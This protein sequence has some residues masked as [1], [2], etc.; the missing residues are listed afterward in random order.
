MGHPQKQKAWKPL[1]VYPAIQDAFRST[2]TQKI[3]LRRCIAS[4]F[5]SRT[6]NI[7]CGWSSIQR[8][9]SENGRQMAGG[10]GDGE[11]RSHEWMLLFPVFWSL[12]DQLR[13]TQ[14][15]SIQLNFRPNLTPKIL[16]SYLLPKQLEHVQLYKGLH[17]RCRCCIPMAR[18][19]RRLC[20]L[21]WYF[22]LSLLEWHY[23]WN[24][25]RLH[26]SACRCLLLFESTFS[27]Q[28][29]EE[30]WRL[31]IGNCLKLWNGGC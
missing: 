12:F 15:L 30:W 5:R 9:F 17:L 8:G 4:D 11:C 29:G 10:K 3:E 18:A 7:S 20:P 2:L 14:K 28:H 19:C 16:H 26:A 31:T 21:S 27:T 23:R 6:R 13:F 22:S 1:V 25:V 24:V